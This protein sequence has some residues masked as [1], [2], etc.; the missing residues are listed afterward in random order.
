M[1]KLGVIFGGKSVEHEVSIITAV[2]AM[3]KIDSNKYEIIPIYVTKELE[4]FTGY[5]LREIDNY[6]DLTLL[7]RN[8]K[9]VQMIRINNRVYLQTIG[10]FKRLIKEIDVVFPIG[11]G[12]YLEDGSLQGMIKMLDVPCVSSNQLASAIGQD[13]VSQKLIYKASNISTS[14][15]IWFYDFEFI[16]E[17]ETILEKIK[18]LKYPVIVKPATL[19]SSVGIKV[20]NNEDE[21]IEFINQAIEYDNKII[22]EEMIKNLKEVNISI[23]GNQENFELS[24]IEEVGSKNEFLTYEDKYINGSKS[25]KGMVNSSRI[26]PANISEELAKEVRRLAKEVYR[27]IGLSGV[28]RLDFLIDTKENKVYMNE[29]NTIP[30]SLSF[31]LWDKTNKTYTQELDEMISTSIREYKKESKKIRTF[32]TNIL[33]GFSGLKGVKGI[34]GIKK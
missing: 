30:G 7:K 19:G 13:K 10:F 32:K 4:F 15:F 16:N 28:V 2:Q 18:K 9:K 27:V 23:L 5:P 33:E 25:R 21:V 11:H 3:N 34:K 22:V 14:D 12:S 29:V 24:V 1:I 26:I 20:S 6:K 8:T 31:Y 17:K